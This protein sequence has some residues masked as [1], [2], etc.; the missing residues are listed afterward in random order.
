MVERLRA[1]GV[2]EMN[3]FRLL[4][5]KDL[6]NAAD[7]D[8]TNLWTR[9]P[10]FELALRRYVEDHPGIDLVSPAAVAGLEFA[11]GP[12]AVSSASGSTTE[13]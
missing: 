11:S 13:P 10:G 6:W 12:R 4:A 3:F 2:E 8:Y 9:R 1:D 5:P 7:D